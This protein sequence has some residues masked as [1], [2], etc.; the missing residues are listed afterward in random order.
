M[1]TTHTSI[2]KDVNRMAR[3]LALG[4]KH[5]QQPMTLAFVHGMVKAIDGLGQPD[6]FYAD[7][8]YKNRTD[9]SCYEEELEGYNFISG[10]KGI[11]TI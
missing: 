10:L 4:Y 7:F 6:P 11:I 9:G 2:T 8:C 3:L 1:N 5:K